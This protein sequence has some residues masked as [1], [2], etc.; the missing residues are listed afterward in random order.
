MKK[1]VKRVL[2]ALLSCLLMISS[3]GCSNSGGSSGTPAGSS[4]AASAN[5]SAAA[6][7][8]ASGGKITTISLY[9]Q[10][11]NLTSGIVGG[12]R[13]DYFASKGIQVNVW[14]YSDE[15]TNAILASGDLPDVMYLNNTIYSNM[16]KGSMLLK[17]DDYLEK[18][19]NLKAFTPA[20]T[21]LNYIR[22]YRSADT[23]SVYF[24]PLNVGTSSGGDETERFAFRLNWQYYED[25]GSP[26]FGTMEE[27]IPVIKKM[28]EAHPT[29]SAG[30]K[31]YGTVLNSGSDTD[32]WGNIQMPFYWSGYQTDL[33][34]CLLEENMVEGTATSILTENSKYYQ[35]LK[36]YNEMYRQGLIDPDSINLDRPTQK[37]K[38][39][40]GDV[41]LPSGTNPGWRPYYYQYY[42]E[43]Q[44]IYY[45]NYNTFG[46]VGIG[47]S[48]K[49]PNVDAALSFLNILSSTDEYL[50]IRG[51]PEGYAWKA[52]GNKVSLTNAYINFIKDPKVGM[53]MPD[54]TD[55]VLWNTG[56]VCGVG[57]PC[58]S[59]K[60]KDG[61][62]VYA[63][64]SDWPEAISVATDNDLANSW[65]KAIGYNTWTEEITAKGGL[66]KSGALDDINPFLSTPDNSTKLTMDSLR[67]VV[68]SASWKMVYAGSDDEFKQIWEKMVSDCNGLDAKKIIEWRLADVE[69]AK[70]ARDEIKKAG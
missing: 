14:A 23:G 55:L 2:P 47:I 4:Q 3:A 18:I 39:D 17:L 66:V 6:A 60:D 12:W 68:V 36:W 63:N 49:S 32:Y 51:G 41:M 20:E 56:F 38:V 1:A 62:S 64:L 52:D 67:D 45:P 11:G 26:A 15:K 22:K 65:K 7:S 37:A 40:K 46:A 5:Q 43:G 24:L 10:N 16:I 19:P 53:K 35:S 61:K 34:N 9:P 42:L 33:L 25:I 44:K 48:A 29:D 57:E 70:A 28:L 13:G 59:Y 21:A 58:S 50:T 27:A 30:N 8:S 31:T 54:G 69:K